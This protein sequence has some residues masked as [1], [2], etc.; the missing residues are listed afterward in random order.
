MPFLYTAAEANNYSN[1]NA[2]FAGKGISDLGPARATDLLLIGRP[3]QYEV[4]YGTY[5]HALP[6]FLQ[7]TRSP[8]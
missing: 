1:T 8:L 3:H 4:A 6:A 5:L 7:S 2:L